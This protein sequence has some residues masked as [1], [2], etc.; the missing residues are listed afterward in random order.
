[1]LFIFDM[2]GVVTST[3][4]NSIFEEAAERIGVPLE[5]LNEA[6]GKGTQEN[7]FEQMSDGFL[8]S[9]EY[10]KIVGERLGKNI[11]ADWWRLLFHPELK[12]ET[13]RLVE[14]LKSQGNRV[15]CGTNTIESHYD[16]HLSRGD[17]SCF[18][19]TYASIHLGVSKP[20][21]DFWKTILEIEGF[22]AGETFFTDDK[23]ENVRAA[24]KLG[25]NSYLFDDAKGFENFI[26]GRI[27]KNC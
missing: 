19:M 16:N 25:I 22:S 14:K 9:R 12:K 23:K 26:N 20:N 4:E 8:T 15:V 13:V 7:L 5:K 21:P 10:W 1:M 17:Y 6:S 3:A 2:G 27:L 11:N 18:D 24:E